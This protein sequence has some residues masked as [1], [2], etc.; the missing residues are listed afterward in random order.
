MAVIDYAVIASGLEEKIRKAVKTSKVTYKEIIAVSP[1]GKNE[2]YIQV[3]CAEPLY[4]LDVISDVIRADKYGIVISEEAHVG[5][6]DWK[7]DTY[8]KDCA[9]VTYGVK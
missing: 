3:E 6:F 7:S 8:I 4:M 1:L 2:F 9:C 5:F